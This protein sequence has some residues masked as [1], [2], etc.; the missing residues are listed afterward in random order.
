M[1]ALTHA[2]DCDM[3]EDC[4]CLPAL[5]PAW[6]D[7]RRFN[8]TCIQLARD[9]ARP[10]TE[11]P[12]DPDRDGWADAAEFHANMVCDGCGDFAADARTCEPCGTRGCYCI[13]ATD[14]DL[15][16]WEGDA[17]RDCAAELGCRGL[18]PECR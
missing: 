5:V 3:D 10:V 15:C 9:Q 18:C 14:G 2:E 16:G 13:M 12:L 7:P 17:C 4:T 11:L 8:R 1:S 6:P